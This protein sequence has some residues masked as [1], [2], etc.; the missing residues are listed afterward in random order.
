MTGAW[1]AFGFVIGAAGATVG[2][3]P[4]LGIVAASV[5]I[6]WGFA[7]DERR[8]LVTSLLIV[9]GFA[10]GLARYA[11]WEPTSDRVA[12]GQGKVL[13]IDDTSSLQRLVALRD[14]GRLVGLEVDGRLELLPGERIAWRGEY[15]VGRTRLAGVPV[16]GTYYVASEDVQRGQRESVLQ[17]V[18]NWVRST[19]LRGV[20]EPSGS[21]ALGILTGDDRG[22]SRGT[23]QVL[24][25]VG[26]SHLTAVSGWNVAVVTAFADGLLSALRA[27][28]WIRSLAILTLVWGYAALTGLEPPVIRAAA[29]ASLYVL[30]RWRGWPRE[31]L[32]ALG[33][34]VVL[35]LI[36]RPEL[37]ASLAFQ[38]SALATAALSV[39]RLLVA[40]RSW[41]ELIVLPVVVQAAVTPLLLARFGTYS[42]VAPL[43]NVLVEPVVPWLLVA[44]LIALIG[45]V[46]PWLA[47]VFGVPA[48]ILGQWI[49]LVGDIAGR[50]PGGAGKSMAP[51][52]EWIEWVYALAGAGTLAWIDRRA[53][54]P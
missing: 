28:R 20:P 41:G 46:M 47:S 52:I 54:A 1:V 26:L 5:A 9:L 8:P 2:V 24:R 18:R 17:S 25:E 34:A 40:E 7:R 16:T 35:A 50:L 30:A 11:V 27:R 19:V 6:A 43:A 44:G 39:G 53:T 36:V 51:P 29:M 32:S 22:L 10:L 33:W 45:G 31:P 48:W 15:R 38:L 12:E 21:L 23:R 49:V 3:L 4:A 13:W 14:D 37:L 42:L